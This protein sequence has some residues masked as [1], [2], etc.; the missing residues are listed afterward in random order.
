VIVLLM[1]TLVL[2]I[3]N[4]PLFVWAKMH[5]VTLG[6]VRGHWANTANLPLGVAIAGE[7]LPIR[8]ANATTITAEMAS[9]RLR[10]PAEGP[11]HCLIIDQSH[12]P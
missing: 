3:V 12:F 2:P 10:M 4:S 5:A 1:G 8:P 11:K 9:A 6:F 7:A